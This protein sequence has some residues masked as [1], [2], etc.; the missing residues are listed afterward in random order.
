MPPSAARLKAQLEEPVTNAQLA[1]LE[2]EQQVMQD[3]M[4]RCTELLVQVRRR[5]P[6]SNQSPV[7]KKAHIKNQE[8]QAIIIKGTKYMATIQWVGLDDWN[9]RW[10]I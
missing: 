3:E 5:L 7:T 6:K 4:A 8:P 9:L 1:A 10:R 2:A